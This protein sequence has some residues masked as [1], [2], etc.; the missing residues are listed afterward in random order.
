MQGK[1]DCKGETAAARMAFASPSEGTGAG[2]VNWAITS[3]AQTYARGLDRP[4]S[5]LASPTDFKWSKDAGSEGS[6]QRMTA[7]QPI[8]TFQSKSSRTAMQV[9]Q[10]TCVYAAETVISE[11][12]VGAVV[13]KLKQ[14][15]FSIT[16][17][18]PYNNCA[19]V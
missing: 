11:C 3:L 10:E 16:M 1:A 13:P 4:A 12:W 5:H 14:H 8:G 6:K 2:A 19:Y 9:G 15:S 7:A 18:T 17:R